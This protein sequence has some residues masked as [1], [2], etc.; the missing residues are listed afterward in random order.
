[1]TDEA[2]PGIDRPL[3]T[4]ERAVRDL[5]EFKDALKWER[6]A[7]DERTRRLAFI[8]ADRDRLSREID[9]LAQLIEDLKES[10]HKDVRDA[11]LVEQRDDARRKLTASQTESRA[12]EEI[13]QLRLNRAERAETDRDN[14]RTALLALARELELCDGP[15][16]REL[17]HRAY[18]LVKEQQASSHAIGSKLPCMC[19]K[20]YQTLD[21]WRTQG[22]FEDLPDGSMLHHNLLEDCT[23]AEAK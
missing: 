17:G 18:A 23:S 12:L 9:D 19:G 4:E 14:L 10:G 22:I 1:M 6:V 7:N 21:G 16:V 8:T 20:T 2:R 13:A 3:T 5:A 11:K 15:R